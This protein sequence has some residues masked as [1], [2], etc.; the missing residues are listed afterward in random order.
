MQNSEYTKSHE[1]VYFKWVDCMIKDLYLSKAII[2]KTQ[3]M[4]QKKNPEN[5]SRSYSY[6]YYYAQL[7]NI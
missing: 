4:F 2:K 3:L 5:S 6:Y 7:A 1:I